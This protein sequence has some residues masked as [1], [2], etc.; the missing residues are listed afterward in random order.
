MERC[1]SLIYILDSSSTEH[2]LVTQL[3]ILQSE[4]DCYQPGMSR[5]A[6]L[7][8]ANKMDVL[9]SVGK[10]SLNSLA[11]VTQLPVLPVSGLHHWNIDVLLKTITTENHNYQ[12]YNV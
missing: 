8:V 3:Q 2:D 5:H 11:Q 10:E 4:L 1:K 7:I 12:L 9:D 6:R